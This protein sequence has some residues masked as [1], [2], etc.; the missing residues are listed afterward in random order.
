MVRAADGTLL[1]EMVILP[2]HTNT[3]SSEFPSFGPGGQHYLENPSRSM[4]PYTIIWSCLDGGDY[5]VSSNI[6]SGAL[7]S[8]S[9]SSGLKYCKPPKKKK[10]DF[11]AQP[12]DETLHSGDAASDSE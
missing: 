1:G 8:A 10:S 11:G 2:D 6:A 9:A 4:T 3:W 7:V 12:G 5:G